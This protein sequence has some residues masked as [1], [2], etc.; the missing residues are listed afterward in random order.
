[1]PLSF[2]PGRAGIA[3]SLLG[4]GMLIVGSVGLALARLIEMHSGV[5]VA[6]LYGSL[7]AASILSLLLNPWDRKLAY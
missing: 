5:T 1:M 4:F 6:A 2:F 7:C 3:A